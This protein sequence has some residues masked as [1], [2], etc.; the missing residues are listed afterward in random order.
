MIKHSEKIQDSDI[1]ALLQDG[2]ISS[3]TPAGELEEAV[4][5]FIREAAALKRVPKDLFDYTLSGFKTAIRI[6][7]GDGSEQ[8][9]VVPHSYREKY[10]ANGDPNSCADWLARKI[11]DFCKVEEGSR[12]VTDYDRLNA[13]LDANGVD[14][15]TMST[16]RNSGWQ[17][18]YRMNAYHRLA[19]AVREA[20]QLD[21]P[22][23]SGEKSATPPN[24]WQ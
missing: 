10:A 18:R 5:A 8:R 6:I 12:R 24:S 23:R 14:V 13:L 22:K 15:S 19:G 21:Y 9:P 16:N 1:L 20:G 7:E 2:D 3:E 11:D 17:G 4:K